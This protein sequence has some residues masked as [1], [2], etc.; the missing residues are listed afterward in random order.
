M[1]ELFIDG[2]NINILGIKIQIKLSYLIC[3]LIL[4]VICYNLFITVFGDFSNG[5]L[6]IENIFETFITFTTNM[7]DLLGV[8]KDKFN[9]Y[10]LNEGF[11][12]VQN[13]NT[14]LINS[15]N[16]FLNTNENKEYT[17]LYNQHFIPHDKTEQVSSNQKH[18]FKKNMNDISLLN[19][20]D[21]S[22]ECCPSTYTNSA[23]CACL[24][25]EQLD[26]IHNRG[27]NNKSK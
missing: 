25:K 19:N 26:F 21:F 14:S 3:L 5:I 15:N 7:I 17:K 13:L 20:N 24:S 16:G 1:R 23:G 18:L 2:H 11:N 10:N 27:N 6:A 12:N 8:M 22:P 4:I 9:I